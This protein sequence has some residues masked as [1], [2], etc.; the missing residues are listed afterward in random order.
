[1]DGN[2]SI[3]SYEIRYSPLRDS[4]ISILQFTLK[5]YMWVSLG[6][7]LIFHI[8]LIIFMVSACMIY[9]EQFVPELVALAAFGAV[10]LGV[11]LPMLAFVVPN[12]TLESLRKTSSKF[13]ER[14]WKKRAHLVE[15]LTFLFWCFVYNPK[16]SWFW[17]VLVPNFL[18]WHIFSIFLFDSPWNHEIFQLYFMMVHSCAALLVGVALLVAV[19]QIF[20]LLGIQGRGYRKEYKLRKV[21]KIKS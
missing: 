7:S 10:C 21:K 13:H 19:V 15:R 3:P 4:L 6:S 11:M 17:V 20:Y 12:E 16:T 14:G 1:M 18:L 8:G 5:M 9:L 2:I